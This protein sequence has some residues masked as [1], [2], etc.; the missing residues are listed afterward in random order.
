MLRPVHCAAVALLMLGLTAVS[1]P[2]SVR[3]QAPATDVPDIVYE[4]YTLPNGLEVILSEDHRLPLVAVNLWYH[5]GPANEEPGR[6]G[7]AHL[8]EHMMFNGSKH[9]PGDSHFKFVEGAGASD[10]NGTT[11]FDRTNYFETLPS[12]QL[13][14]GLWL[15]SDR[16]GYLLDTLTQD[17]LSNQQDVV[18]NE[19]RQSAESRPYGIVNEAVFQNLYPKGH[20]YYAN[21]IGSHA[22]IQAA[23]LDD[24]K[25]FFKKYYAPNNATLVLVGDFDKASAKAMVEK[26]FGPLKRG[27]AVAKPSV[28]TP[29]ITAEKRV[30][31]TDRIQLPRVYL[32]WQSPKMYTQ[33]DA[34]ADVAASALGGGK[35][36][37][38][39]KTLVYDR[40][41]A[42]DVVAYQ[43][44]MMLGSAFLI[45]ATARP[46]HTAEELEKAID[47]ELTTFQA[48]GPTTAEIE[49]ARKV[50]SQISGGGL[51]SR[52]PW[53][54]DGVKARNPYVDA[55]N[56]IQ[57]ELLRR[58]ADPGGPALRLTLQGIAAGLRTTG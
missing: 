21:I 25:A 19:R 55:L 38:L 53:L 50:M 40:Q 1:I 18:R 9:V 31:V 12:N 33:E 27:P 10:V 35:A 32:T 39:Y 15:E 41:I 6:T 47:E 4:K 2:T 29:P 56:A 49:L 26:Y 42:Q 16:M 22:D 48:S 52:L 34:D 30:T 24:V 23:Q 37:R 51:D 3:A 45:Q 20:P 8:F 44:S 28:Q 11:G 7:F 5:V 14:L 57:V 46:G 13:E 54:A 36:S 17:V 43:Q 58:Q